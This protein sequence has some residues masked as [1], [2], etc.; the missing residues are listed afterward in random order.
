M[1]SLHSIAWE[2][3]P[4]SVFLTQKALVCILQTGDNKGF[5]IHRCFRRDLSEPWVTKHTE[6]KPKDTN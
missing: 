5:S 1:G 2:P 3:M 6:I 4:S